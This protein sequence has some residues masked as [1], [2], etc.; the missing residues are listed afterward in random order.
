MV[1]NIETFYSNQ[2]G[3][4]VKQISKTLARKLFAKGESIEIQSSKM[5]FDNIW[6]CPCQ[7]SNK[8]NDESFD[9]IIN[10][11]KN[12]NCDKERGLTVHYFIQIK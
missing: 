9:S 6:Q 11:Y 5:L 2:L 3:T 4:K 10:G 12:Y 7:I 8:D 1:S